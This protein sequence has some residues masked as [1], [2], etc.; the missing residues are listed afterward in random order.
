M[1][2]AII[3][4]SGLPRSGTSLLMQM[5]DRGGVGLVTDEQRLA[6][7]DNPKGYCEYEPVK[8]LQQD[9]SWLSDC[10]GKAVKVISQLLFSLPATENYAIIL[11]QRDLEEVLDSQDKMLARQ[12]R[13]G[14]AREILRKAFASH[15]QKLEQWLPAQK[16]LKVLRLD[17]AELVTDPLSAAMELNEFLGGHLDATAMSAAVDPQLYRNR[18]DS[19]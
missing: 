18:R 8:R 6:D 19:S 7:E 14:A 17:Y 15:L 16:N 9:S 12:G 3:V 1:D 4:V 11:M 2:N 13:A 5:L 10:Q